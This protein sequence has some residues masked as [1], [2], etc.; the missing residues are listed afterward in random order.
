MEVWTSRLQFGIDL[1]WF[2]F[3]FCVHFLVD[4]EGALGFGDVVVTVG[5]ELP[6]EAFLV[7]LLVGQRQDLQ[8]HQR[9]T[10]GLTEK[11]L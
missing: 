1:F 9:G 4:H 10:H 8:A 3:W 2:H 5:E 6:D 11:F 7:A